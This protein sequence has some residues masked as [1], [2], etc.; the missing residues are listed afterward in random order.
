MV[1]TSPLLYNVDIHTT[2]AL[3]DII[4][5]WST[6]LTQFDASFSDEDLRTLCFE[7]SID[8][9]NLPGRTK[10][11]R[12]RELITEIQRQGRVDELIERLRAARPHIDWQRPSAPPS[13][14]SPPPPPDDTLE[15]IAST[16]LSPYQ[17]QLNDLNRQ[18]TRG[19]LVLFIGADLPQSSTGIPSRAQMAERLA[20]QKGIQLK[21]SLT[22]VSQTVMAGGN[23]WEFTDFLREATDT[24]GKQPQPIHQ[25]IVQLVSQHNIETII[26]TTYD[27]M[28]EFTFRQAGLGLNVVVRD[29]ELGFISPDRPTLL[30]LYGHGRQPDT[31]I[32]TEQDHNALLRNRLKAELITEIQHAYRRNTILYIGHDLA[33]PTI[34][35]L[36]DE[37]THER[38]PRAYAA[39]TGL[40]QP[41]MEFFRSQRN[42]DIL[43]VDPVTLLQTLAGT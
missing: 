25:A 8:Y 40:P 3:G 9:E 18:L 32:V 14:T 33:D 2:T 11:G 36:M 23:R 31:L 35:A 1:K 27:D 37:L 10:K 19:R 12:I 15:K 21:Q 4:V 6:L 13:Q 39:W 24:V 42:C 28:L 38:S 41:D 26:T 5:D 20:Q 7:M 29:S 43:E 22:A 17:T 30:R 34:S 16:D